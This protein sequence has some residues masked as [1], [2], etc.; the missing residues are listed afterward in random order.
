MKTLS[1]FLAI[2]LYLIAAASPVFCHITDKMPDSVAQMEYEILLD[3][4][5]EDTLIRTKYAM[6]KFRLN[7]LKAAESQFNKVLDL[8]PN[9]Y[10]SLEG[11]G[12][13]RLKQ[14]KYEQAVVLFKAALQQKPKDA[15]GRFYLA[16]TYEASSRDKDAVFELKQI[17]ADIKAGT[18]ILPPKT[19][20]ITKETIQQKIAGF[21]KNTRKQ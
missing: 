3:L 12:R 7:K 19:S 11:L 15:A 21:T 13:V 4:K 16:Q 5:P 1:I 20:G 9:D 6:V 8:L 2:S 10:D 14:K 18:A 17:M